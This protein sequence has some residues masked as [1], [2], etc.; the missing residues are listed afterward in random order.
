ML[1][2]RRAFL[3]AVGSAVIAVGVAVITS[4]LAAVA[5]AVTMAAV[6]DEGG[7]DVTGAALA[8]TSVG[9]ASVAG[10]LS[11][12]AFGVAIAG[13]APAVRT[14]ATAGWIAAI[15]FGMAGGALVAHIGPAVIGIVAAGS[16]AAFISVQVPVIVGG[17]DGV[18]NGTAVD[19][20]MAL[21]AVEPAIVGFTLATVE[22]EPAGF[23]AALAVGLTASG[24]TLIIAGF[25]R[26]SGLR[27]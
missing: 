7:D 5:L 6:V 21:V 16:A 25:R 12:V 15:A 10:G 11:F 23:V 20:G 14:A 8:L 22:T 9:L 3:G 27:S 17:G 13:C 26:K 4:G 2:S 1:I 18:I 19:L 24:L